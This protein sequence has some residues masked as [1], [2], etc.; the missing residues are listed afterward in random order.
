MFS[1]IGIGFVALQMVLHSAANSESLDNRCHNGQSIS[2]TWWIQE[3][4]FKQLVFKTNTIP[5][6]LMSEILAL[7]FQ[8]CCPQ[9]FSLKYESVLDGPQNLQQIL[10]E[11][12][13]D[14][15]APASVSSVVT[16]VQGYPFIGIIESPSVAILRKANVNG[17]QLVLSVLKAWP[18]MVFIIVS[19][20]LAG[21]LMWFLV[22]TTTLFNVKY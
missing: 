3:P 2:I 20:A 14:V 4:Y 12:N 1:V 9:S 15:L 10:D 17:I 21:I 13:F 16:S 8:Q 6:G 7:V 11:G 18:L 5:E 19:A 22:S